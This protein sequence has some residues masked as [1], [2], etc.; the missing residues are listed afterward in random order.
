VGGTRINQ[1]E[2]NQKE[3]EELT[4]RKER[5]YSRRKKRN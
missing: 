2:L 4:R 5:K 3:G 1:E